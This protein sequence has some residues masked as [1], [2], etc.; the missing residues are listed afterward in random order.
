M[1]KI[2]AAG[3]F[4]LITADLVKLPSTTNG[5]NYCLVVVD[6]YSKWMAGV[7]LKDKRSLSVANAFKHRILPS[8]HRKPIRILTDNG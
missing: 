4:D 3:P 7:P 5:N 1:V 8:L 2:K 6:H